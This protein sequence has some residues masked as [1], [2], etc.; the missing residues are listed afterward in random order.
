MILS[1]VLV[2]YSFEVN[3]D[4]AQGMTSFIASDIATT[5]RKVSNSATHCGIITDE[6]ASSIHWLQMQFM[7]PVAK[8]TRR[9]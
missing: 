4:G 1:A 2:K 8:W 3:V 9:E 7:Q 6:L 5:V